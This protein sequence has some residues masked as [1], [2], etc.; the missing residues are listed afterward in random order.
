MLAFKYEYSLSEI[1]NS[2]DV[3]FLTNEIAITLKENT[4]MIE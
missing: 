1:F 4:S 3:K 2:A